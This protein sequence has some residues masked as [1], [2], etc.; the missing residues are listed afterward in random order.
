MKVDAE[1]YEQFRAWFA[2]LVPETLPAGLLPPENDPVSCLD[3]LASRSPA[4]ARSGLAMAVGDVIETTDS[5]SA[6]KVADIDSRLGRDG[7]PTLTEMRLRFS[8]VIRRVIKRGAVKTD[9]EYYA[10]RNA[11]ELT[12]EAALWELIAAYEARASA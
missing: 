3:Q 11:A 1:N 6:S 10:L 5:W 8:K 12:D 4:K 9:V 7:L 2:R